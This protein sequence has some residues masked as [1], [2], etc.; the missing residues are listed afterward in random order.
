MNIYIQMFL[1]IY[2]L[3]SLV[4]MDF[5]AKWLDDFLVTLK[6]YGLPRQQTSQAK[7]CQVK[8]KNV[9]FKSAAANVAAAFAS[10][11]C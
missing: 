6:L 7:P 9:L 3:F 8:Y 1:F 11:F 4:V 5:S 2:L 10:Y